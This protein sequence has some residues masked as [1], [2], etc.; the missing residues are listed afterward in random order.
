MKNKRKN[1][2][3]TQR[4][5]RQKPRHNNT[6]AITDYNDNNHTLYLIKTRTSNIATNSKTKQNTQKQNTRHQTENKT[7]RS[8]Q[9]NAKH[10]KQNT[11]AHNTKHTRTK[12]K[13]QN[14]Q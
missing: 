12:E 4:T 7:H 2:K 14:K 10:N 13:P 3:Q 9:H 6:H 5:H 8:N 11:T 1:T